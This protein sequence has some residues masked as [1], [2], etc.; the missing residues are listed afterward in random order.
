MKKTTVLCVLDGLGL[1]PNKEA[2]AVALANKPNL[3]RLL[4][5]SPNTTL[6]THGERVGLPEGQM[7]NSEVG[8]LNIGAG[9]VVEQWLYRISKELKL[10][11]IEQTESYI[12]FGQSLKNAPALHVFGLFSDGGVHSQVDHLYLLCETMRKSYTGKIYLHLITDGRDTAPTAGAEYAATLNTWLKTQ[13][14]I[15]IASVAGRFFAMDRDNRWERVE[16][17]VT[18]FSG[19]GL[20]SSDNLVNYLQKSYAQNITDEFIEPARLSDFSVSPNDAAIFWNFRADRMRELIAALVLEDFNGFTRPDSKPIF[21]R[22]RILQFTDYNPAFK[23]PYLFENI[24]IKNF[25]GEAISAAGLTQLRAAET[26][27]YPHVTYFLNGGTETTCPGEDREMVPS[28]RDVKTYDLKPEMSALG[29]RDIVLSGIRSGKYDLI[30]VNFANC[31]M[32]GHTGVIEAAIK[33]VETV[34]SCLG[35]IL[36]ALDQH[37]GQALIIADHGNAEQMLNYETRQPHTAHTLHPV[38]CIAYG[39][40]NIKA[41]RNGGALCD[42]APTILKMMGVTQPVEMTGSSLF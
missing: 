35:E 27:K 15:E 29:V 19:Q 37:S 8:H 39:N 3:D 31:D 11:S 34:D 1:N 18:V 40:A 22:E 6:I 38:P 25:L 21:A 23:L 4:A 14:N 2:N 42:V 32:V 20:K 26:E 9:R 24:E 12:K 7:G 28:P 30:V 41:L 33:A 10:G 5:S 36:L 16:K 17:A 13:T